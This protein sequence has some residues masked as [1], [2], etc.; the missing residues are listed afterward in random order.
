MTDKQ[1]SSEDVRTL[2]LKVLRDHRDFLCRELGDPARYLPYLKSKGVLDDSGADRIKSKGTTSEKVDELVDAL[3]RCGESYNGHP[4]DVLIDGIKRQKVQLHISR[5]LLKAANKLIGDKTPQVESYP[6][7]GVTP[8]SEGIMLLS[9]RKGGSVSEVPCR[10]LSHQSSISTPLTNGQSGYENHPEFGPMP[11]PPPPTLRTGSAPAAI[12]DRNGGE[13]DPKYGPLPDA[14]P[15]T[16]RHLDGDGEYNTNPGRQQPCLP[17]YPTPAHHSLTPFDLPSSGSTP[18]GPSSLMPAMR[19]HD[20]QCELP[21][22]ASYSH[23]NDCE[24]YKTQLEQKDLDIRSLQS[25]LKAA[26]DENDKLKLRIETL[27]KELRQGRGGVALTVTRPSHLIISRSPEH[28]GAGSLGTPQNMPHGSSLHP[29]GKGASEHIFTKH[30][31]HSSTPGTQTNKLCCHNNIG[32][33]PLNI[34]TMATP[35][36]PDRMPQSR[37]QCSPSSAVTLVPI[38]N[39]CTTDV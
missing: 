28:H 3:T 22:F 14:P 8:A 20:V 6:A 29:L 15:T 32:T 24:Y 9:D 21:S 27:E 33:P 23:S 17:M 19:G 5:V 10:S 38:P 37:K 39:E 7:I 13:V 26:R 30:D 25:Q 18:V 12:H 35:I 34:S 4:L 31:K 11:H 16:L 2:K 1:Q 36:T